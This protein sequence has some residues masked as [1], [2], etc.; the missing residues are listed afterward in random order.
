MPHCFHFNASKQIAEP[1]AVLGRHFSFRWTRQI[2]PLGLT[3]NRSEKPLIIMNID[4]VW[5]EMVAGCWR[6]PIHNKMNTTLDPWAVELWSPIHPISSPESW[7]ICDYYCHKLISHWGFEGTSGS[8]IVWIQVLGERWDFSRS[9][10]RS[11]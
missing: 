10:H 3:L 11:K 4:R 7:Q 6:N 9:V 2:L 8:Q 5:V 1:F